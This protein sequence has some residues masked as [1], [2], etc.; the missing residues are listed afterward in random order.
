M[1]NENLFSPRTERGS[2]SP[3]ALLFLCFSLV[4]LVVFF[5]FTAHTANGAAGESYFGLADAVYTVADGLLAV[6][7]EESAVPP[8]EDPYIE[9]A[10]RLYIEMHNAMYAKEE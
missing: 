4:L 9:E 5:A 2:S 3:R 6:D 10:A 7:R 8:T 1:P